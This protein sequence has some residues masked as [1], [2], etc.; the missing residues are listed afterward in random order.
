MNLGNTIRVVMIALSAA[1]GSVFAGALDTSFTYQGQLKQAGAP[2]DGLVDM[3][4]SL[5]DAAE[6]GAQLGSAIFD[7]QAANA[8]AVLVSNGL[9]SIN[10]D[11]GADVFNGERRYLEIAVRTPHDP[12]DAGRYTLL[13]PR[14]PITPAPMALHA[15]GL[16]VDDGGGLEIGGDLHTPGKIQASAY[17]SNSPLIFQAQGNECARFDDAT[18]YFGIGTTSPMAKLHV[19]GT[20]GVDGIMFPDGSLQTTAG[21]GPGGLWAANGSHIHTTNADNVGIGVTTPVTK[22]HVETGVGTAVFGRG[23]SRGVQ[24]NAIGPAGITMG[25]AGFSESDAGTGVFGRALH[26]SGANY[27]VR[28]RTDS[29]AGWAGYFEG[30]TYVTDKLFVG[31]QNRIGAEYFGVHAPVADGQYGGMY[32]STNTDEGLPFYGYSAGGDIDMWHY[33]DGQTGSWRVHTGG[34]FGGD[35]LT[36]TVGGDV[37]V[38][39]TTP[40]ARLHV[41][42]NTTFEALY[43]QNTGTG[44]AAAFESMDPS[45]GSA[46]FCYKNSGP[47]LH[48]Y[49]TLSTAGTLASDAA[50]AVVG[51]S[52]SEPTG[53][54]FLVCGGTNAANISIDNNEI[55]A[56][57]NGAP[58]TLYLNNDGGDVT[59]SAA[60]TGKLIAKVIQITGADLAEKFPTSNLS[61]AIEPGTVMEIDPDSPGHLRIARGA[62]NRRVAGVVSGA[63]GLSTGA[64]LGNLP[65]QENAPAI[66]LSGRVW[67][68]CDAGESAIEPGDLLTTAD[69]PGHAMKVFDYPRAQG[70]IIGKAMTALSPAQSGLVLVL[71]NLQ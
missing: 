11:F 29:P 34:T 16:T 22:L 55:M 37:G 67:V 8:S 61:E 13:M 44:R 57:N 46:V 51:G 32:I 9:F 18:C 49:S 38:G 24:G 54:G 41:V 27:G 69:T 52:D 58:S 7:G 28:G 20:P 66:A 10:L 39:T 43:V 62:Y 40:G 47:A 70:A 53:G 25:V 17:D 42:K 31:R 21:G 71:V 64:V 23:S 6:G 4:V 30:R 12:A 19:A 3:T 5:Y 59:V 45:T 26:T 36:V 56:R 14:Q 15:R 33:L 50:M 65:G 1:I 48:V 35:R 2:L 63:N 60:G 68:L